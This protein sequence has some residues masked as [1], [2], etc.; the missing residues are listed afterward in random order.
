ME[1]T[2]IKYLD[3]IIY[4]YCNGDNKNY[5]ILIKEI[6]EKIKIRLNNEKYML[7]KYS[8]K[9]KIDYINYYN[10]DELFIIHYNN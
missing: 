10:N 2:K 7:I 5:N 6:N 1:F 9:M 3:N 8:N 4:D